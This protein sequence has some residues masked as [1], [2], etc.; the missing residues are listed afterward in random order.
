MSLIQTARISSAR[1]FDLEILGRTLAVQRHVLETEYW[2]KRVRCLVQTAKSPRI[3]ICI[4]TSQ[5]TPG[6][7]DCFAELHS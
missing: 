1:R 3:T 2:F 7:R 4:N 6:E 5:R